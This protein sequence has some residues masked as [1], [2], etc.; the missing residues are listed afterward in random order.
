MRL[1]LVEDDTRLAGLLLRGLR[2][3]GY[4]VDVAGTVEEARWLATENPFDVLIFDVM[5]PDG[6]GFTL[7]QELRQA[8]NWT[9]VL[10]LTARDSVNDRVRG[11]DAGADDYLV[12][13]HSFAE[14]AARVRALVRRG[15]AERPAVLSVGNLVLDPAT[16]DVRVDGRPVTVSA[17]EFALLELFMRQSDRV[18]SR[19]EILD[20][21]WDWA[22]DG[23]SNVID[24][25]VRYL[26]Q[27]IGEGPG[28]P[29]IETV[30]G[31]GYALRGP[32]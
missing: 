8:G 5:L 22:Y 17:K 1:L 27:K 14:L 18:L 7:C 28:V 29:R 32:A 20:H 10:M 19:T 15:R 4:A 12:K 13:P 26:R 9:P 21:V 23:T 3:E 6:D 16:H 2:A 25:Y 31:V 30:R 11:L 24:V